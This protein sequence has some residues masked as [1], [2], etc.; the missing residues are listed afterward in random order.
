MNALAEQIDVSNQNIA[1]A[2]AQLRGAAPL[3]TWRAALFST[4]AG[5]VTLIGSRLSL[6][7][8]GV[9]DNAR[10][11]HAPTIYCPPLRRPTRPMSG[12][13]FAAM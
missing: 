9:S 12:D 13:G 11:P 6:N 5:R 8:A 1:I 3:S 2:E 10:R 4:I 7:R